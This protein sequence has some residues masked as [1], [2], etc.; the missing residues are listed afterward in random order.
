M[1]SL[2]RFFSFENSDDKFFNIIWCWFKMEESKERKLF[3]AFVKNEWKI[4]TR[5]GDGEGGGLEDAIPSSTLYK[6]SFIC[7]TSAASE[8]P[9]WWECH[10]NLHKDST[11][12]TISGAKNPHDSQPLSRSDTLNLFCVTF[13]RTSCEVKSFW[14]IVFDLCV[15]EMWTCQ[16]QVVSRAHFG[17]R[18]NF[19][20]T[21]CG[22]DT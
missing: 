7:S 9:I 10:Q 11:F 17:G 3:S 20:M 22:G 21:S 5:E 6:F 2:L 18:K 8:I 15:F 14:K 13:C 12:L 1:A 19:S 16:R 4:N